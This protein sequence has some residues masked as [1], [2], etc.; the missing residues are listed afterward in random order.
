MK[1]VK[2]VDITVKEVP[3]YGYNEVQYYHRESSEYIPYKDG[4]LHCDATV[5]TKVV[6]ITHVCQVGKEDV[7][8]AYTEKFEEICGIPIRL[9]KKSKEEAEK[10]AQSA[11]RDLSITNE[12]L[13]KVEYLKEIKRHELKKYTSASFIQRLKYLFTGDLS[14]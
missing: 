13:K 10:N 2:L 12:K 14:N 9:L 5:K 1:T 11:F 8:V 6:P 3:Y 4:L 7:A